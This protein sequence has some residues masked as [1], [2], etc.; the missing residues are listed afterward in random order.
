LSCQEEIRISVVDWYRIWSDGW[1]E[2]G[3]TTYNSTHGT[4]HSLIKTFQNGNY[5]LQCTSLSNSWQGIIGIG[6]KDTT[7][8]TCWTSDDSSF[9]AITLGYYAC[10]Y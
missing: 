3:G 1:I 9:N 10:G 4:K 7:Y 5:D 6:T 8:F 2:Q